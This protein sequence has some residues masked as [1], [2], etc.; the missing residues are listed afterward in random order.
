MGSLA[1]LRIQ[2]IENISE[3]KDAARIGYIR[4]G[5]NNDAFIFR[6]DSK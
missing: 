5:V 1:K 4:R 2:Q 6:K 3:I